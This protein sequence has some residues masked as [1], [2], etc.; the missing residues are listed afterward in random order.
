M[1]MVRVSNGGTLSETVLWTNPNGYSADFTGSTV[2]LSQSM[3]NF[4]YLKFY[5]T[6][7]KAGTGQSTWP[8]VSVI[9]EVDVF[10]T[11]TT[12]VQVAS[13]ALANRWTGSNGYKFRHIYY[14]SDTSVAFMNCMDNAGGTSNANCIPTKICGCK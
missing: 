8:E 14:A 7:A 5:Y 2:A 1:P 4:K 11:F 12:A 9:Y 3:S 13:G 6:A 10:K